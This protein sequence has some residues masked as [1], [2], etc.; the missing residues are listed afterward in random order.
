M[1]KTF[2][3]ETKATALALSAIV[4]MGTIP[5]LRASA[6]NTATTTYESAFKLGN[7]NIMGASA[8]AEDINGDGKID[9][10]D[11]SQISLSYNAKKG[12]DLYKSNYDLVVDGIIDIYDI[13]KIA[14]KFQ[15]SND[16]TAPA[17]FQ[18]AKNNWDGSPDYT[19]SM[20][21]WYGTNGDIW[22]LYE[23]NVLI[24]EIPLVNA[25]PG[26]Q[27]AQYT[28]KDKSN[29]TYVYTSE[30]VNSVGVTQAKAPVTHEV[31][32][33]EKPI[34]VPL[35]DSASG[36]PAVGY[37]VLNETATTFEWAVFIANPNKGYVWEGKEF[38]AWGLSFETDNQVTSVS[39]CGKFVQEGNKVTI[40]LKQDER[41]LPYQTTK[42]FVVKGNKKST[43][44]PTSF[45]PN[46]FR[47]NL[48]YPKFSGLPSTWSKNKANLNENDLIANKA[49]YYSTEVKGNTGNMLMYSKPAH[50]TQMQLG[51]PEKMPVPVN[52][53]N[54]LRIWIPS[55]Y[56]A[57][58]LCT[59]TEFFGLNPNFMVGLSIKENFT[60]G[61]VPTES[62][63]NENITEYDGK[64]WAWPIQ[65]LHPDG[66]FQ[67]EKGNFNEIKKQYPDYLPDSAEHQNYVTLKTG[68]PD[69][70][71]YVHA[72]MSSY[73]SLTM[74]REFLYAIPAN[75][76]AEFVRDAN[77]TWA[78][79]VL[80]D[81][82]YNRGVYGLLQRNLFTTHRE[83]ALKT[84]DLNEEFDLGGFA[85]HIE[86]IKSII[87]AMDQETQEVYD[88]KITWDM[89]ENYF[90]ELRLYYGR[91]IPSDS[92]WTA[93]K[94]DVKRA[95]DILAKHWGGNSISYRYDFLTLL[96][97]AEQYL[98]ENKQPAPSSASWIEQ[99]VSANNQALAAPPK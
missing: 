52:G 36:E 4:I 77:D 89:M 49:D 39:N 3:K 80:V 26:A 70:P 40:D 65:K 9:I 79:Y 37:T 20:N 94:A 73:M 51:L 19:I 84:T 25:S 76:F 75:K 50:N 47:G 1:K 21:L 88:A 48:T 57:M 23:N 13:I 15:T 30:L 97:V 42:V 83:Q 8:I 43:K 60:C 63:Y 91:G 18:I 14:S 6:E 2:K 33:N 90:E 81:N 93:M 28:F 87:I 16:T 68:N 17:E 98:P 55:E 86:T 5:P 61:L 31:T 46:L 66:P 10:L 38:S 82:A 62:G 67:Q 71:S 44:T 69:D 29:G 99:I 27:T 59:G 72:A 85:S 64:Q 34:I 7:R 78:E 96:R 32:K 35:P 24:A 58:G 53:V 12:S 95:F 92:E 74:T 54:G 56:L 22:R 41:L 45:T 11:L